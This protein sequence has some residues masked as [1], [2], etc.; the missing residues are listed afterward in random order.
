MYALPNFFFLF[1]FKL[2]K[3][4]EAMRLISVFIAPYLIGKISEVGY[5]VVKVVSESCTIKL[6][7]SLGAS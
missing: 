6:T 1:L 2:G 5:V 7:I 4:P 3:L